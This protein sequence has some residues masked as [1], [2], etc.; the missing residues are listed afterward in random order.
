M[1]KLGQFVLPETCE[2]LLLSLVN[3][4]IYYARQTCVIYQVLPYS[5]N[6]KAQSFEIHRVTVVNVV[7]LQ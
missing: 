3:I 1:L 7:R 2:N 5:V 4:C 6:V